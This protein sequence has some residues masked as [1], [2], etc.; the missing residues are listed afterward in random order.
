MR[1]I[2]IRRTTRWS[3]RLVSLLVLWGLVYGS[4]EAL[5]LSV[6]FKARF[7]GTIITTPFTFT[8]GPGFSITVTG[9]SNEGAFESQIVGEVKPTGNP[10]ELRNGDRGQEMEFV[11]KVIVLTFKTSLDQLFLTLQRGPFCQSI[12]NPA[13]LDGITH[14]EVSG[15]TGRFAHASGTVT[16]TWNITLLAAGPDPSTI[17]FGSFTGTFDGTIQLAK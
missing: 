1:T 13:E 17:F 4:P 14:F 8:G 7:A 12:V 5:D 2:P 15:G 10:C 16:E 3:L 11:G 9:K 6:A